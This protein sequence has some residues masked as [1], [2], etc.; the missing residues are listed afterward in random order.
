MKFMLD[1]TAQGNIIQAYAAG[2]VTVS[3]ITYDSSLIVTP[4]AIIETWRP[5]DFSMLRCDDFTQLAELEPEIVILGTGAS[6]QFPPASLCQPLIE[7]RIGMESMDT[8]AACRTYNILM[9]EGRD[10]AAALFMI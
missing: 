7:R 8:A 3:G 10:I 5:G 9:A 2:R 1:D 4:A 6:H